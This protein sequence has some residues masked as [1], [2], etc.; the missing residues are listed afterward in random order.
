MGS[1]SLADRLADRLL[2]QVVR[3]EL[4]VDEALP[5]EAEIAAAADVSRLTVREAV[6]VLPDQ[7]HC[8]GQTRARN[9]CQRARVL[10]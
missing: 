8:P 7:E 1:E 4:A 2:D 6:K 5:S 3:G 10:D 9:L